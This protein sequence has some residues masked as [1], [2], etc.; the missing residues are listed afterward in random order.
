M[1]TILV[2]LLLTM[3]PTDGRLLM[4]DST[5][6]YKHSTVSLSRASWTLSYIIDFTDMDNTLSDYNN[7]LQTVRD[8][9]DKTISRHS[10]IDT[11]D[12]FNLPIRSLVKQLDHLNHTKSIFENRFQSFKTLYQSHRSKRSLIPLIGD[13]ANTLFGVAT[14]SELDNIKNSVKILHNNQNE[15]THV[16]NSSLT[17]IKHN[18][19]NVKTNRA[20]LIL[21][22]KTI[23]TLIIEINAFNNKSSQA[24]Q[25]LAANIKVYLELTQAIQHSRQL[26]QDIIRIFHRLTVTIDMLTSQTFSPSVVTPNKLRNILKDI[27]KHLPNTLRLPVN[28]DINIWTF[29]K[30]MKVDA[31]IEHDMIYMILKIP[32]INFAEDF[33]IIKIFNLPI[34]NPV[35]SNISSNKQ[36]NSLTARYHIESDYL[37]INKKRDHY[38]IPS[39]EEIKICLSSPSHFCP[40][41]SPL[42]P[43][44]VPRFC[45]VALFTNTNVDS[46]CRVK[47]YSNVKLPIANH[48]TSGIWVLS[49][50][51]KIT[52]NVNCEKNV[53]VRTITASPPL[54]IIRLNETCSAYSNLID[55]PRFYEFRSVVTEGIAVPSFNSTTLNI[56][57]PTNKKFSPIELSNLPTNDLED[58]ED[59]D[60]DNL[61]DTL[62]SME[63]DTLTESSTHFIFLYCIVILI[64]VSIII[65]NYKLVK[66]CVLNKST[67]DSDTQTAQEQTAKDNT[68]ELFA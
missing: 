38:I 4:R 18:S 63:T 29:Y 66:K 43:T 22:N 13:L 39:N 59:I 8:V 42:Y 54:E 28:P 15:I 60:I 45:A 33:D 52:F 5:I 49:T 36:L 53:N 68:N 55:L 26:L 1:K 21:L 67:S 25:N 31:H 62:S 61:V 11:H 34:S 19:Q 12:S 44:H 10:K 3:T 37:I 24:V 30:L 40:V 57:Q 7:F 20:N 35:F 6:F 50:N 56:W 9:T 58:F 47:V 46:M 14:D 16:V 48:I 2:L 32:L 17:L 65:L 27:R 23:K 64:I 51:I 41:E